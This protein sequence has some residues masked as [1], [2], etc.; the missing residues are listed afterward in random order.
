MTDLP[1]GV[2]RSLTE[3]RSR[4]RSPICD[5]GRASTVTTSELRRRG[6]VTVGL[7]GFGFYLCIGDFFFFFLNKN[8]CF[9]VFLS[10]ALCLVCCW[11]SVEFGLLLSVEFDLLYRQYRALGYVFSATDL[12]SLPATWWLDFLN[13]CN[14]F[15]FSV[16]NAWACRERATGLTVGLACRGLPCKFFFFF[17]R[18]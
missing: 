18:F 12:I 5:E 11:L 15:F 14:F 7:L 3:H 13:L 9:S 16:E 8:L 4:G 6:D 1:S 10:I 17:F 2:Y